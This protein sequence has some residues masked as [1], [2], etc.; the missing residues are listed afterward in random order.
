M[1][2]KENK[3][4]ES[5]FIEWMV[6][7]GS[8]GS[9]R[10]VPCRLTAGREQPENPGRQFGRVCGHLSNN[11]EVRRSGG[12][13]PA[14]HAIEICSLC[15]HTPC[16]PWWPAV[17]G[18]SAPVLAAEPLWLLRLYPCL[19]LDAFFFGAFIWPGSVLCEG[20]ACSVH[21]AGSLIETKTIIAPITLSL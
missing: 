1:G 4:L 10:S 21:P 16:A 11:T 7:S 17:A 18:R 3:T 13:Q 12:V 14:R 6:P 9:A 19:T 15:L 2:C 20:A 8:L 5:Y